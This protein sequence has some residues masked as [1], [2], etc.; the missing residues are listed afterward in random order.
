MLTP[1]NQR[2]TV[3]PGESLNSK[4]RSWAATLTD[5]QFQLEV[6]HQATAFLK[7]DIVHSLERE[8]AKGP[9]KNLEELLLVTSASQTHVFITLHTH[10]PIHL[11]KRLLE[12]LFKR[13]G[14]HILMRVLASAHMMNCRDE[15]NIERWELAG[16]FETSQYVEETNGASSYD[17]CRKHKDNLLECAKAAEE[18]DRSSIVGYSGA[19]GCSHVQSQLCAQTDAI[20]VLEG[21]MTALSLQSDEQKQQKKELLCRIRELEAK[22]ISVAPEER[23]LLR[24]QLNKLEGEYDDARGD[25]YVVPDEMERV[26]KALS[27]AKLTQKDM[28]DRLGQCVFVVLDFRPEAVLYRVEFISEAE[29]EELIKDTLP[30]Q[31]HYEAQRFLEQKEAGAEV[32]EV[33]Q[34]GIA[35]QV[36]QT[37]S[38]LM[39]EGSLPDFHVN[40]RHKSEFIQRSI[41]T[42]THLIGTAPNKDW[43]SKQLHSK[44]KGHTCTHC[45]KPAGACTHYLVTGEAWTWKPISGIADEKAKDVKIFCS[46]KC[47]EKWQE[48]LICPDCNTCDYT[49]TTGV[50]SYPSQKA[51]M[52]MTTQ[53]QSRLLQADMIPKEKAKNTDESRLYWAEFQ[54]QILRGE[55]P[56][57]GREVVPEKPIKMWTREPRRVNVAICVTCSATMLPRNPL[58]PHLCSSIAQLCC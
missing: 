17:L 46:R 7:T 20:T 34:S 43:Y 16:E 35:E 27:E 13:F 30:T 38:D 12:S 47:E 44:S 18:A 58:A 11:V 40:H 14:E 31:T 21:M 3:V 19:D 39:E 22:I 45:E 26:R 1:L 4:A 51:L 23:A 6:H 55:T 28:Q 41:R 49:K 52:D 57:A 5:D 8:G 10:Q 50:Q 37:G 24:R 32:A 56:S 2:P 42:T 25:L 15:K 48:V 53:Y 9:I 33:L 54:R 29:R 36:L